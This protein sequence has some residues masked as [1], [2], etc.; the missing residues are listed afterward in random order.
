MS[1]RIFINVLKSIILAYVI[2]FLL[3]FIL[4]FVS[5]QNE[6]PKKMIGIFGYASLFIGAFSSG[7]FLTAM[8]K[9]KSPIYGVISGAVYVFTAYMLSLF[10]KGGGRSISETVIVYTA[11]MIS[12]FIGS[13]VLSFKKRKALFKK[14]SKKKYAVAK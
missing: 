13:L 14:H 8:S 12:S 6:D 5:Y 3:I 4:G 11:M 7:L 10:Y 9:K 2:T 1:V